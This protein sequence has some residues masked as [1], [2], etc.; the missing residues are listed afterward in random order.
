LFGE[1][2]IEN[3]QPEALTA[4]KL[5]RSYMPLAS[6]NADALDAH[7]GPAMILLHPDTRT[8]FTIRYWLWRCAE[9]GRIVR[10]SPWIPVGKFYITNEDLLTPKANFL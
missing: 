6:I 7:C 4:E 9:R 1:T 10:V 2:Y 3:V 5:F 8:D